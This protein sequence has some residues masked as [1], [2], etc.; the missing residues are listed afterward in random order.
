MLA[1]KKS[2]LIAN[3]MAF[4]S[5]MKHAKNDLRNMTEMLFF[6]SKF[7]RR[8]QKIVPYICINTLH[9]IFKKEV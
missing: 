7:A 6:T 3:F 2:S 1:E 5:G 4:K 8:M 9:F